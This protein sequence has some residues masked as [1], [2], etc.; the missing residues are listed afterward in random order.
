MEKIGF[1]KQMVTDTE[2]ILGKWDGEV[3]RFY[4]DNGL[5]RTN[6]HGG[7]TFVMDGPGG[8]GGWDWW[9][10]HDDH[11]GSFEPADDRFGFALL[12]GI[13][14]TAEL[15]H[16]Y[17]NYKR[18]EI[19]ASA[20]NDFD[21]VKSWSR[22]DEDYLR[23][24]TERFAEQTWNDIR[25]YIL[26]NFDWQLAGK[27]ERGWSKKRADRELEEEIAVVQN[28]LA[29]AEFGK[30]DLSSEKTKEVLLRLQNRLIDLKQCGADLE[31]V[32][33]VTR[34]EYTKMLARDAER[35]ADKYG[36]AHIDVIADENLNQFNEHSLHIMYHSENNSF[37]AFNPNIA[38]EAVDKEELVKRLDDIGVG[39]NF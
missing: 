15:Y 17:E 34:G 10:D 35:E 7:E 2:I 32:K 29:M 27:Y 37:M 16:I 26:R 11:L 30:N 14:H 39:H 12:Q 31:P 38:L 8:K 20:L 1:L 6:W 33:P 36:S 28:A 18:Y 3:L 19:L 25:Y 9:L 4:W 24:I 22:E 5:L 23:S 13:E 21:G